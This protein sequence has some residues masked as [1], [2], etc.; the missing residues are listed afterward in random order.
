MVPSCCKKIK[1]WFCAYVGH[2]L[3]IMVMRAHEFTC[4]RELALQRCARVCS[5]AMECSRG[6]P[7]YGVEAAF[8]VQCPKDPRKIAQPFTMQPTKRRRLIDLA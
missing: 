5:E 3:F 6:P 7:I 1:R 4:G 8:D 2:M